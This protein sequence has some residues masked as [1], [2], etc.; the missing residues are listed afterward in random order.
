ME[1]NMQVNRNQ[2]YYGQVV[3]L[4]L[5][6]S[7]LALAPSPCAS[8]P[9]PGFVFKDRTESLGLNIAS[10]GVCWADFDRDGWTDLCA[11]GVVWKNNAGK[12]FTKVAEN[13][14][15]CVAADFDN[16]GFVDLFSWSLLR[17]YRNNGGK[18][19]TPIDL[20]AFPPCVSIGA[21]CGDFNGDGFVDIYVGGFEDWG[22]G[23]TYPD[24]LLMSD[25]GQ[26]FRHAWSDTRYR[27]RGVTACDFDGDGDLDVYV[28]NYR[29]QPNI[30]WLNDGAGQFKDVTAA[31]NAIATSPGFEGGHSIGAVW[32]D[33]DNDGNIDL[34]AGNFAH[35]DD[36]GDQ[37]K[38]RFL[39]NLGAPK[40]HVF[41]D[42]GPCR[43]FYQESYASP[44]AG[45]YDNDGDLDLFFT[46]VYGVASFGRTNFPV[47]YRNDGSFVLADATSGAQLAELP[48]TYQAAWADFDNDGDLDLVSAGKLFENQ[49]SG[50]HYLEVCLEGD[51]R[52]VNRS[53]IGAQV[54][55][56]W[57]NQILTRQV[58]AGTGQ[59]N[60]NDLTLHFGL[61]SHASPVNLEIRWPNGK[62]RILRKV[63]ADRRISVSYGKP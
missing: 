51:G 28:S 21:C 32:G 35:Q 25:K 6:L 1:I 37:P 58:E 47:L 41:E 18:S 29:L 7:V 54:R 63:R 62:T 53:A 40:G 55:I 27:A 14:G 36:R 11:G 23:I 43:V 24:L 42:L 4:L 15:E 46:T 26:G 12:S 22:A 61:G 56:K 48:P 20:P 30:L 50:H 10:A 34:F 39:R 13:V 38:S 2:P 44:S 57:K 19:F 3:H 33:F 49:G 5:T 31:Y 59:G 8:G 52:L 45:D 16:D 9:Q 17:V 60:Q